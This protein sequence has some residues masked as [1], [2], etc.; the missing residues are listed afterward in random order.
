MKRYTF[1]N[2]VTMLL[3]TV[4]VRLYAVTTALHLF[5]NTVTNSQ[6]ILK[7]SIFAKTISDVP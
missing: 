7:W 2:F 1:A 5:G 4:L 3:E 6:A